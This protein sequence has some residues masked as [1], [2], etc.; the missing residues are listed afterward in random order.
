M[1]AVT[2]VELVYPGRRLRPGERAPHL[3]ERMGALALASQVKPLGS[4]N[5]D[6]LDRQRHVAGRQVAAQERA[7][8]RALEDTE[9]LTTSLAS[10]HE[11]VRPPEECVAWASH[12]RPHL[13]QW[14]VATG[15][16]RFIPIS[17]V[18]VEKVRISTS[19]PKFM[20]RTLAD[21][22]MLLRPATRVVWL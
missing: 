13:V 16:L 14:I 1:N 15:E 2:P 8:L 20:V 6:A 3:S 10:F 19:E 17:T 21:G 5:V 4:I 7:G 22:V 9:H 18:D 11:D 12:T